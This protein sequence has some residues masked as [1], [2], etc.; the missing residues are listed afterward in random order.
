MEDDTGISFGDIYR[1]N[2]RFKAEILDIQKCILLKKDAQH[3]ARNLRFMTTSN[4][5]ALDDFED[6]KSSVSASSTSDPCD[7]NDYS[8]R[9][10]TNDDNAVL[11]IKQIPNCVHY[12]AVSY[13]WRRAGVQ[14]LDTTSTHQARLIKTTDGLR[15]CRA[16]PAIINRAIRHARAYD[17]SLVWIDQE[18]I[19]QDDREDKEFGIQS[20]DL[21]YQ[22]SIHPVGILDL[23]IYSQPQL[24]ALALLV[25]GIAPVEH[26]WPDLADI[27]EKVAQN[28][29]FTR[30]WIIQESTSAQD[31]T[32]L[33]ELSEDL[34]KPAFM[35]TRYNPDE[36]EITTEEFRSAVSFAS[37]MLDQARDV[38]PKLRSRLERSIEILSTICP[39]S[40]W[41]D[42]E[43]ETDSSSDL[44][45]SFDPRYRYACNAAQAFHYLRNRKNS[46]TADRL[47]IFANL[48]NY[49]V[50]LN[51]LSLHEHSFSGCLMTLAL[52]NGDITILH[53]I[54]QCPNLL[55]PEVSTAGFSWAPDLSSCLADI[56]ALDEWG[57]RLRFDFAISEKGLSTR[58]WLW[59][60]RSKIHFD[61][62]RQTLRKQ[63]FVNG[64]TY[65]SMQKEFF[66][67]LIC[68]LM[69]RQHT[70]LADL[71]WHCVRTSYM[72]HSRKGTRETYKFEVP[73]NIT[74]IIDPATNDF[75]FRCP[76]VINKA[77]DYPAMIAYFHS[78]SYQWIYERILEDGFL[79]Y[80]G[81][82]DHDEDV[83]VAPSA[84]FDQSTSG[85]VFTPYGEGIDVFPRPQLKSDPI[86]WAVE[87]YQRFPLKLACKGLISGAFKIGK[88]KM[89]D[90]TLA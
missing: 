55:E 33:I 85:Y 71:V 8:L 49:A 35:T 52:L 53:M 13:C 90:Y 1:N 86:S 46:R 27:L 23:C 21:T 68:D 59:D 14:D 78:S 81:V 5:T 37:V 19:E 50:R 74:D 88:A 31:M 54:R 44:Q 11:E 84:I 64:A 28:A 4:E 83:E 10:F 34:E 39:A 82:V 32:L 77:E 48:C 61:E 29:W 75:I 20:M 17:C 18:C 62:L 16:P 3:W 2:G 72:F 25:E 87:R 66:W 12:V 26:H 69:K 51:T 45:F 76:P 41:T 70:G 36:L 56:G 47:A 80:G 38:P 89:G 9:S 79:W 24:D 60:I 58:G 40:L 63:I 73:S 22:R 65:H 30:A 7:C 67:S 15:P 42:M 57:S 43:P 6:S